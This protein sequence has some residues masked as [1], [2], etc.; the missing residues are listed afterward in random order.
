M[1]LNEIEGYTY[2][3]PEAPDD[4]PTDWQVVPTESNGEHLPAIAESFQEVMHDAWSIQFAN[5]YDE[6]SIAQEVDPTNPEKVEAQL[7]RIRKSGNGEDSLY[8]HARFPV[9][10]LLGPG[11][12]WYTPA[13]G[14]T[15]PVD[16][17]PRWERAV[18][19]H[20]S[21]G[22]Y[23]A[24]VSNVFVRPSDV[25]QRATQQRGI[26]S[27]VLRSLLDA[28]PQDTP[29]VVYDYPDNTRVVE[30]LRRLRFE[31]GKTWN[32]P[33]F[34]TVVSQTKYDGPLV[35]ELIEVIESR[36][37]WLAEREPLTS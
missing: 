5:T 28:Y 4:V 27:S 2:R 35:G 30:L 18:K 29:T 6:A 34:G 24:D 32:V 22:D 10:S 16:A 19:R 25:F 33:L 1:K 36:R 15:V 8:V 11:S 17:R 21:E 13:I 31:A 20:G 14:K 9:P 3:N 12:T 23:L 7:Q 26:G 37:P